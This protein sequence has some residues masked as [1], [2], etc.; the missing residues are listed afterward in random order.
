MFRL[1]RGRAGDLDGW[2][3]RLDRASAAL[4]GG[5][6]P[7][8]EDLAETMAWASALEGSHAAD[9]M[10]FPE[11]CKPRCVPDMNVAG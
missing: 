5:V 2:L 1:R 6:S 3:H 11:P 7:P 8:S 4:D 10:A 9:P